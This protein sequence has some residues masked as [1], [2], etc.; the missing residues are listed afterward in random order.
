[1]ARVASR[2]DERHASIVLPLIGVAIA[3]IAITATA[4]APA[5]TEDPPL[6]ILAFIL[7]IVFGLLLAFSALSVTVGGTTLEWSFRFGFWR[8][9]LLLADIVS[10]EP[11]SVP[12]WFGLGIRNTP[13][14]W[15]YAVRGRGAVMVGT[16]DGKKVLIGS[17]T[18]ER[19]AE[20][21]RQR[22][23]RPS[24]PIID[25]KRA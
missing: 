25:A 8:K 13:D 5:T 17:P 12:W 3:A 4:F 15:Y 24:G 2:Y 1:M 10:V 23:P 14:G 6:W 22:M 19:L 18:P 16:R 21:I 7:A 11:R 20:A 9:R